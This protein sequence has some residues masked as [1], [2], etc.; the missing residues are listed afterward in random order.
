[1][2]L[3]EGRRR[4]GA[5]PGERGLHGRRAG[6]GARHSRCLRGLFR[7]LALWPGPC[8]RAGG[9]ATHPGQRRL[10]GQPL[11][12][13][14]PHG[15]R[16]D[17][18]RGRRRPDETL[19]VTAG[20]RPD[21]AA[22]QALPPQGPGHGRRPGPER[23][24]QTQERQAHQ[25]PSEEPV[26]GPRFVARVQYLLGQA[27]ED[28]HGTRR[29]PPGRPSLLRPPAPLR[30]HEGPTE[31]TRR[32]LRLRGRRIDRPRRLVAEVQ[33]LLHGLVLQPRTLLPAA[34]EAPQGSQVVVQ[35]HADQFRQHGVQRAQLPGGDPSKATTHSRG[36]ARRPF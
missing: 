29:H 32:V 4:E 12:R 15:V 3:S 36:R 13:A 5:V 9:H 10:P 31:G 35:V 24:V 34:R 27:R 7:S 8:L 6:H 30:T 23:G 33:A 25:G 16:R 21:L 1:M 18:H 22:R 11:G 20:V 19:G 26:R 28:R 2:D 17:R 14:L